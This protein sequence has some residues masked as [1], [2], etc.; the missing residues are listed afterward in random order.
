MESFFI[1]VEIIFGIN[2]IN[3]NFLFLF[4]TFSV[5]NSVKLSLRKELFIQFLICSIKN[6]LIFFIILSSASF[7]WLTF[8]LFLKP[9]SFFNL[10]L[11]FLTFVSSTIFFSFSFSL[12]SSISFFVLLFLFFLIHCIFVNLSTS[13]SE[14]LNISCN[15]FVIISFVV[16]T[17][18]PLTVL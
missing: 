7:G 9:K 12:S 4:L 11:F 10:P 18:L 6:V 16:I 14:F 8:E 2:F 1:W 17:G 3:N 15:L 13:I 5:S